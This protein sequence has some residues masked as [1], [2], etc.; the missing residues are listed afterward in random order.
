MRD[1]AIME[2]FYSSGLRLA[3]LVGLEPDGRRPARSHRARARQR[4]Q[5]AH[6]ARRPTCA[7]TRSPAGSRSAQRSPQS[8]SSAL[9]VEHARRAAAAARR[10]G[11]RRGLGAGGRASA[12]MCT[13]TCSGIPLRRT[14]SN[15]A[16][17]CAACRN[18]SATPISRPRRSTP[19]LI[20]STSPGST[21]QRTPARSATS[22]ES[23][24]STANRA[25]AGA[26]RA[27]YPAF[28]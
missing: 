2:L 24:S 12:C 11:A 1:K 14:C 28:T 5:D 21:T 23:L 25:I 3:E 16:R 18:C 4:R 13:R 19:T 22:T 8:A 9:F 10:A 7:S 17:T 20:F 26:M 15:R 27:R 6:R